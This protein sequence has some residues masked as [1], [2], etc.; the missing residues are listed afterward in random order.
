MC[1]I[2]IK[3]TGVN[4]ETLVVEMRYFFFLQKF[5]VYENETL[6]SGE[7]LLKRLHKKVQE[8]KLHTMNLLIYAM[9]QWKGS[10]MKQKLSF[11]TSV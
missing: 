2:I 7:W 9:P 6:G 5:K 11:Q 1:P 3:A 4:V 8:R 10:V